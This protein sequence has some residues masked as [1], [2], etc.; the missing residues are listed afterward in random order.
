MIR[1]PVSK[2][3]GKAVVLS[4]IVLLSGIVLGFVSKWLDNL[5]YEDTI[6]WHRILERLDLGN[7]LSDLPFWLLAAL[8]IAVYS[9]SA[10]WAAINVFL[11]FAGMCTAYHLYTIVFAGFNPQSYMMIW[12]AITLFS[13]VLA[14]FCW[15][16][17][18]SGKIALL[19]DTGIL[20]VL[21][22]SC[23]SMGYFYIS[24]KGGLYLLTFVS[25]AAVLHRPLRQMVPELAAGFVLALIVSP[26][27][28]YL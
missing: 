21:A 23:F 12:Y 8:I 28:F 26:Y 14:V 9:Y 24:M 18:G 25:A 7:F 11:F 5:V 1:K 17:R 15:Y 3:V 27:W 10:G 4:I 2:P 19:L 16:A 22:V 6:G 13:P 20:A